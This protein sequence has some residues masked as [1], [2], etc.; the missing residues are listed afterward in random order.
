MNFRQKN[1]GIRFSKVRL[2]RWGPWRENSGGGVQGPSHATGECGNAFSHK[3][4][5]TL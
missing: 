3:H 2:E 4:E 1:F 5:S